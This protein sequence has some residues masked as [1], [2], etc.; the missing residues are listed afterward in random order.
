ME[1]QVTRGQLR[2]FIYLNTKLCGPLVMTS[3]E[4]PLPGPTLD[5]SM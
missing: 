2:V 1:P 3:V 4:K 5:G